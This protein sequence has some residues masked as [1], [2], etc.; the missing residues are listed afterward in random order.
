MYKITCTA[1]A[2]YCTSSLLM[3]YSRHMVA[4]DMRCELHEI[5]TRYFL[6]HGNADILIEAAV[7]D[8]PVSVF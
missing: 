4:G 3:L 7:L 8:S 5:D 2:V 6:E 1:T